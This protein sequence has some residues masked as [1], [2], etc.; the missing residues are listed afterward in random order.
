[1]VYTGKEYYV[2]TELCRGQE[3]FD[4]IVGKGHISENLAAL[5]TWQIL[6]A[7]NHCHQKGVIHRDIKPEN[8]LFESNE[9]SARLKVTGFSICKKVEQGESINSFSGNLFYVAPE[10]IEGKYDSKCDIWS[11]GVVLS[12][13]LIGNLPFYGNSDKEIIH[14]ILNEN[15]N[16][17]LEG[18][19]HVSEQAK[20]LVRK[21]LIKDPKL[22]PS[23]EEIL[24]DEWVQNYSQYF[25]QNKTVAD[26][27]LRN[28]K[29][30]RAQTKIKSSILNFIISHMSSTKEL[31]ELTKIFQ[32]MDINGDGKLSKD[33]LTVGF[34][35]LGL[36]NSDTVQEIMN[37]CDFDGSGFVDF[38]EFCVAAKNW[39]NY[40]SKKKI[41][42]LFNL[43]D[44]DSSGS[45]DLQE[46][47][48]MLGHELSE[49][50]IKLIKEADTDGNGVVD[51]NEFKYF[52]LNKLLPGTTN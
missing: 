44:R 43:H 32:S 2:V 30:F 38:T 8:L 45:I 26:S 3:L 39:E 17:E 48:Q 31:D 9:E 46:F 7:L 29:A 12:T 20:E 52:I 36:G 28:L 34:E 27:A 51:L 21:M 4:R 49:D 18:W 23:A 15:V 24:K 50:Y 14:K 37:T 16:F 40:M 47:Q 35:T 22:R 19:N 42:Q 10:V 33:E 41:E 25:T 6:S 1:M 11:C 13:M 5:Y